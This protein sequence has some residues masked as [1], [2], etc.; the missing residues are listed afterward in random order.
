MILRNAAIAALL[1][2]AVALSGCGGAG[3]VGVELDAP[4]LNA[5][6]LDLGGKKKDEDDLPERPGLVVPP[7]TEALPAPGTQTA[8]AGAQNWPDDP[9]KRKKRDA[10]EKAAAEEKYCREGNWDSKANIDEFNKNI[11]QEARCQSKLG[12]ALNNSFGRSTESRAST[13]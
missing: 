2:G 1:A 6:G 12:K 10:A 8:A 3:G 11:G 4:I 13:D 7:S 9:D 5:V